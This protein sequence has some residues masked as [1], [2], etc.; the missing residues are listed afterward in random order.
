L[1]W[2]WRAPSSQRHKQPTTTHA[3]LLLLLL[4]ISPTTRPPISILCSPLAPRSHKVLRRPIAFRIASSYRSGWTGDH[5][6]G[7]HDVGRL[8]DPHAHH[9]ASWRPD[10]SQREYRATGKVHPRQESGAG[11]Q[12]V[13]G[14]RREEEQGGRWWTRCLENRIRRRGS[15]P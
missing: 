8:V 1:L 7:D 9:A 14:R 11:E 3:P 2:W 10:E 5:R 13:L 6:W 12:V 4:S 15:H